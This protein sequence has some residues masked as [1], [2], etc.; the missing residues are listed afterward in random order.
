MVI[1]GPSTG[2]LRRSVMPP[3]EVLVMALH[4]DAWPEW[5]S[6]W[7]Y[8]RQSRDRNQHSHGGGHG[9]G[10]GTGQGGGHGQWGSGS[11]RG[12]GRGS[13]SGQGGSGASSSANRRWRATARSASRSSR[14]RGSPSAAY[15]PALPISAHAY[16]NAVLTPDR[17]TGRN[18][19]ASSSRRN[20]RTDGA[21]T[22][23]SPRR[24]YGRISRVVGNDGAPT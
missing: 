5:R 15:R 7:W 8:M 9:T 3:T 12:A 24:S 6:S 20:T 17:H 11:G 1:T 13:G 10:R 16:P 23:R 19:P 4:P 14:S 18:R 21:S 2:T 22:P